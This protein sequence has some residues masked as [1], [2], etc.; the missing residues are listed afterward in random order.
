[1]ISVRFEKNIS[2]YMTGIRLF[3]IVFASFILLWC[4]S[5]SL[6]DQFSSGQIIVYTV[7]VISIAVTPIYEPL[8]LFLIY[9]GTHIIFLILL[10]HFQVSGA[11][12]FGNYINATTFIIIS[13]AISYMRYKR[14]ADDFNNK[15]IIQ[16]QN[17]ELNRVN[18]ALEFLSATDSLT[19]VYN[20]Y[21]FDIKLKEEWDK[22]KSNFIPLSLIM[23]DI[24]YFKNI[25]DNYGHQAGDYCVKQVSDILS[26]CMES[27]PGFIARYGGDEFVL[28]MPSTSREEAASTME[29]IRRS[30]AQ[31]PLVLPQSGLKIF[32]KFSTGIAQFPLDGTHRNELLGFVDTAMYHSKKIGGNLVLP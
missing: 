4:A 20:R 3:G 1:L 23:L 26:A 22:C 18:K 6:L 5:I 10:P 11:I 2:E 14:Q 16:K 30:F 7:A 13:W 24:D 28:L 12:L 19:G 21:M 25:N 32:L 27:M 29:R 15:K 31:A 8:V 9:T 17:E